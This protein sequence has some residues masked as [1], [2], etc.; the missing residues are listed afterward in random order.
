MP[1]NQP[2]ENDPFADLYGRLPDPRT[3][4][5]SSRRAAA[6]GENAPP[7][8]RAAREARRAAT[9]ATP[10]ISPEQAAEVAPSVPAERGAEPAPAPRVADAQPP[11]DPAASSERPRA[12]PAE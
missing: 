9:E 6:S 7:S 8:R 10:T 12:F 2:P 5:R 1:E 3:G 4:A 11:L